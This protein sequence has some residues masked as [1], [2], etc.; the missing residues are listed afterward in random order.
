MPSK[1]LLYAVAFVCF[2]YAGVG[3]SKFIEERQLDGDNTNPDALTLGFLSLG[4]LGI[5][6]MSY[7]HLGKKLRDRNR[8]KRDEGTDKQA[9][10]RREYD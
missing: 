10:L 1:K 4:A 7:A 6:A 8:L 5:F 2:L 3:L 9:L